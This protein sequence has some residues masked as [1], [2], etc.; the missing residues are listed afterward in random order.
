MGQVKDLNHDLICLEEYSLAQVQSL[1]IGT[2]EFVTEKK[3]GLPPTED[4]IQGPESCLM[5][6]HFL[7]RTFDYGQSAQVGIFKTV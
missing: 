3:I 7:K 4:L 5:S 1:W 2:A 6:S